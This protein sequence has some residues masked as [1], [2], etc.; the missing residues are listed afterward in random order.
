MHSSLF[1]YSAT[2]RSYKIEKTDQN[3][4]K[5]ASSETEYSTLQ[6]LLKDPEWEKIG[7]E[8]RECLPPSEYGW[9]FSFYKKY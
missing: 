6:D 5:W 3:K 8:F 9:Y 2:P 7:I 4:F 1:L